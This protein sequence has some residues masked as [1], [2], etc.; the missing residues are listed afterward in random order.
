MSEKEKVTS[1]EEITEN[2][3]ETVKEEKVKKEKTKKGKKFN[4][5][6]LKH[7]AMATAFTCVFIALVVLVNVI[8][9]ILF[10]KYPITLDLTENKIYSISEDAEKYVKKI[11][12]KVTVT[13]LANRDDFESFGAE[14]TKT[15]SE[16]LD[17]Y[18]KHND[19]I[20]VKYIDFLSNPDVMSDYADQT[21]LGAYDIIF[22]TK[23][24]DSEGNEFKR[25]KVVGL[26]DMVNIKDE[27]VEY[28]VSA[29]YDV[30]SIDSEIE[31]YVMNYGHSST[32]SLYNSYGMLGTSNAETAFVT[33]FMAVADDNPITITFLNANRSEAELPY[34]KSLLDANGYMVNEINISTDAIPEDSNVLV[35]AAPKLDYTAEEIDKIDKFLDNNGDLNKTLI[36]MASVEQGDTPNIDEFLEEYGLVIEDAIIY[37]QEEGY[38]YSGNNFLARQYLV[39]EYYLDGFDAD[40]NAYFYVPYSRA[41]TPLYEE[42]GMKVVW[43]YLASSPNAYM[44]DMETE[45]MKQ[46]GMLYSMAIGAKSK[47]VQ[48]EENNT[49]SEFSHII[50]FGTEGFFADSALASPMFKNSDMIITMLNEITNKKQGVIITPKAVNAVTFD[51]NEKQADVL[52][53]TFVFIIPIVILVTGFVIYLRRKNK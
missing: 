48:D 51:I 23:S 28:Y 35:M 40:A 32:F 12:K 27:I 50:A 20:E 42:D 19:N 10:D 8:A 37:E 34:F 47:F 2:A 6:K 16:I 36:Y 15:A 53:Y 25:V 4:S 9:T 44:V 33:A 30:A 22:E 52:K 17:K 13:V 31:T 1:S 38:Y 7:G 43:T 49:W 14:Y 39:G 45:K 18:R 46:E 29:G 11:D 24:V 21:N 26:M 5:K 41:I 3:N